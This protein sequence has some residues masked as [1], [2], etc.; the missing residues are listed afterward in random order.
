M[1]L[2]GWPLVDR[3]PRALAIDVD[4][5]TRG[6]LAILDRIEARGFDVL[7]ERPK[8]TK[9]A[10]LGLLAPAL[11]AHLGLTRRPSASRK[12]TANPRNSPVG[13]PA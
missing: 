11:L 7:S 3:L 4:L 8:L 1:F 2:Q 9:L 10:K 6:G 12:L 5:F 13:G